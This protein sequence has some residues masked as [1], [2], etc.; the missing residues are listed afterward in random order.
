VSGVALALAP[1]EHAGMASAVTMVVRKSGFAIR[2]A[3]SGA[4]LGAVNVAAG[5]A[6]PFALAALVASLGMLAAIH[7]IPVRAPT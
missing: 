7:L 5:F 2:I 4:T 1:P 3:E 6:L